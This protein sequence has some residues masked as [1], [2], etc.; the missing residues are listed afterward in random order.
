MIAEARPAV[1]ARMIALDV[2]THDGALPYYVDAV[3][4]ASMM[5]STPIPLLS[6]STVLMALTRGLDAYRAARSEAAAC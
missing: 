1:M 5:R 3:L 6:D 2:P 4:R